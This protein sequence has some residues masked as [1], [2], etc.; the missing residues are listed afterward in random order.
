MALSRLSRGP[1][2]LNGNQMRRPRGSSALRLTMRIAQAQSGRASTHS[3]HSIRLDHHQQGSY[4][5][6]ALTGS[7]SWSFLR[8][9]QTSTIDRKASIL[10]CLRTPRR[11]LEHNKQ[12]KLSS[13]SSQRQVPAWL[14]WL[15]FRMRPKM[16]SKFMEDKQEFFPKTRPSLSKG[17]TRQNWDMMAPEHLYK[18]VASKDQPKVRHKRR[19]LEQ[20]A[21]WAAKTPTASPSKTASNTKVSTSSTL[22]SAR[23]QHSTTTATLAPP[24]PSK[25][26]KLRQ[27]SRNT[28]STFYTTLPQWPQVH[29]KIIWSNQTRP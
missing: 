11:K 17:W 20:L 19:S 7:H 13:N 12:A 21:S 14:A 27:I 2:A 4:L 15:L 29:S 9:A 6:R 24:L 26:L 8:R 18:Q 22:T 16:N 28:T 5:G 1:R 3:R 10:I 23:S 25:N